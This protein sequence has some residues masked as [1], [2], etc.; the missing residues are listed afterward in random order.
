[1]QTSPCAVRHVG[2][3]SQTATDALSSS[4]CAEL[5]LAWQEESSD[6]A[7]LK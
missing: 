7:E 4:G 1:M 5:D 2:K 6:R 3:V